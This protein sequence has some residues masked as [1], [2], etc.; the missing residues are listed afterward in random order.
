MTILTFEQRFNGETYPNVARRFPGKD[1]SLAMPSGATHLGEAP[2]VPQVL[3]GRWVVEC[4]VLGCGGAELM[5]DGGLFF[6]CACRNADIGNAYRRVMLPA[7]N[8]RIAVEAA[9][10]KRPDR[11]N[12]NF[13]AGETVAALLAEN[14]AMLEADG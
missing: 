9:L 5:A 13:L 10:L 7:D 12:R 14:D 2:L 1:G 3:Q 8:I 6:C 4:P 11:E